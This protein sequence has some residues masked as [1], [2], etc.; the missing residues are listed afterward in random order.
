MKHVLLS[1]IYLMLVGFSASAIGAADLKLIANP[2]VGEGTISVDEFRSVFLLKDSSLHDGS[3]VEPVLAKNGPVHQAMLGYLG[4]TDG[5]LQAYYR[6]L[7]FTGKASIPKM[8][9][10]DAEM[11]AYVAKTKGAIGCVSA[12]ATVPGVKI[13][14]IQ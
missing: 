3:H 10:S 6:S 12:S 9:G 2:T 13:I 7:V 11:T 8:L 4:K 5:G 14:E 1:A